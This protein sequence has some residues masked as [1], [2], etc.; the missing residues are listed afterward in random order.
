MCAL[1]ARGASS[2]VDGSNHHACSLERVKPSTVLG[3]ED[4]IL[5]LAAVHASTVPHPIQV[6]LATPTVPPAPLV[7]VG[8]VTWGERASQLAEGRGSVTWGE[9]GE[10]QLAGGRGERVS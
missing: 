8:A 2:S 3:P 5:E 7:E 4:A 10:G 6:G 1:L 9:R